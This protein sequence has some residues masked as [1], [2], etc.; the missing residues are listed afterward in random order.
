M[1]IRAA[2]LHD[3]ERGDNDNAR[4][5]AFI[6]DR[7][8]RC[9]L[10]TMARLG[11]DYDLLTY[12]GD[13][14]RLKFWDHAFDAL[15]AKGAVFRQEQGRLA[16]CWVMTIEDEDAGGRSRPP[17]RT[18]RAESREK[19]IVRSD[20]TVTYVGK[21]IANQFWKFGLLGRDFHYRRFDRRDGGR[22]LW[23]TTSDASAAEAGAGVPAF[24]RADVVYNVIDTRQSYLQKLLKQAL[25]AMGYA[26]GGGAV[27]P[28]RVRDGRAVARDGARARLRGGGR[29]EAGRSSRC[30]GAR[31][32]ASRPTTCWTA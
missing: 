9:H 18:T 22:P 21:D 8:V 24:G 26:A 3:I 17:A 11:I 30:R 19:V 25:G 28:L 14:L 27:D 6:A 13:I 10:A 7:I 1:K 4:L 5:G 29:L 16:G 20:G 15:K 23:A 31:A 12:E 32:W 2:T